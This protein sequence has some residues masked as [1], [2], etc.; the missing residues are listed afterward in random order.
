MP[1]ARFTLP[2]DAPLA[3]AAQVQAYNSSLK[4][5]AAAEPSARPTTISVSTTAQPSVSCD[6]V[7]FAAR[8]EVTKNGAKLVK[9]QVLVTSV[10]GS[11]EADIGGLP[12]DTVQSSMGPLI[13]A[14]KK[15][16]NPSKALIAMPRCIKGTQLAHT[17]YLTIGYF[18]NDRD[19]D[20]VTAANVP[21][22]SRI[23]LTGVTFDTKQ[24]GEV[25]TK[26]KRFDVTRACRDPVAAK[27]A[28]L[29]A[30]GTP[31]TEMMTALELVPCVGG[32]EKI[33]EQCLLLANTLAESVAELRTSTATGVRDMTTRLNGILA[34]DGEK[35]A[36]AALPEDTK[37]ELEQAAAQMEQAP[38]EAP[39]SAL[40]GTPASP[41][42]V[43]SGYAPG[44][45][46]P[47]IVC[48]PSGGGAH[49]VSVYARPVVTHVEV[50]LT[51][52]SNT[53][54]AT[55]YVAP[56]L[57]LSGDL[58][59]AGLAASQNVV[60]NADGGRNPNFAMKLSLKNLAPMFGT[61]SLPKTMMAARETLMHGRF[62]ASL[63]VYPRSRDD[64]I[65]QDKSAGSN[66]ANFF[67]FGDL[68]DTLELVGM[69]LSIAYVREAYARGEGAISEQEVQARDKVADPQWTVLAPSLA[70]SGAMPISEKTVLLN[71]L[72]QEH[73]NLTYRVLLEGGVEAIA[74]DPELRTSTDKA[75]AFMRAKFTGNAAAVEKA[76]CTQT[77]LY[78]CA[79]HVA[80]RTTPATS[81]AGSSADEAPVEDPPTAGGKATKAKKGKSAPY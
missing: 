65:F 5:A 28:I 71:R 41:P 36:T 51:Q 58:A 69:P 9:I 78:A 61:T 52:S 46:G 12:F 6:G 47:E 1:L 60:F 29:S 24:T 74:A 75:E 45:H 13:A 37:L 32:V 7:V 25:E 38:F 49:G 80:S 4:T 26:C 34:G 3:D 55:L 19:G 64:A 31:E 14:T 56:V 72:E 2:T 16:D 63:P 48:N 42:L 77:I 18:K 11:G 30:L 79:P 15:V 40:F 68:R 27:T 67:D 33:G 23:K 53:G 59:L 22:G 20:D 35:Y 62:L 54:M 17:R 81:D 73:P 21:P 39:V 10:D 57:A 44:T 76:L 8:D 50:S 66:F 43:F 70:R